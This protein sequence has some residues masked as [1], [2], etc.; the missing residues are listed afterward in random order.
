MES[1]PK[2][3]KNMELSALIKIYYYIY[4]LAKNKKHYVCLLFSRNM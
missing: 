1:T 2:D 4:V 3:Q